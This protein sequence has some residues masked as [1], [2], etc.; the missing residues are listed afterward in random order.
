MN[1][2]KEFYH[3]LHPAHT[4]VFWPCR[5]EGE[6][7]AHGGQEL[8]ASCAAGLQQTGSFATAQLTCGYISSREEESKE[9]GEEKGDP[10][11]Q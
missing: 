1:L 9:V 11:E 6:E 7:E 3:N 10:D 4:Q 5:E 2:S 8:R